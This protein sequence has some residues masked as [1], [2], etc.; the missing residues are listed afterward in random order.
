MIKRF[1]KI[2]WEAVLLIAA[3]IVIGIVFSYASSGSNNQ[4][5]ATE[6]FS[7]QIKSEETKV[8]YIWAIW[9]TVCKANESVIQTN[10]DIAFKYFKVPFYSIEEGDDP[11]GLK[12]YI[13]E[14]KLEGKILLAD[15]PFMKI[16]KVASYPT[17][18]FINSKNEIVFRD[19][20]IVSPIGFFLR[21][22]LLKLLQ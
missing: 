11:E 18:M 15:T 14:K 17:L 22:S 10:R 21:L 5:K 2:V 13:H 16:N 7:S 3:V 1:S 12:K 19:T 20:G 4:F 9:C 6:I 8:V